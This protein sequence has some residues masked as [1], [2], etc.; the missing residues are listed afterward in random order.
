M[1]VLSDKLCK[2]T[3]SFST[4]GLAD[5]GF[6]VSD[7]TSGNPLI[8]RTERLI[9]SGNSQESILVIHVRSLGQIRLYLW[10]E[11]LLLGDTLFLLG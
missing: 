6:M 1:Y 7:L 4:T 2:K 10:C 3:L 5:K 9:T 8:I 11:K